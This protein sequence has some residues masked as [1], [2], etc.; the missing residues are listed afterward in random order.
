MLTLPFLFFSSH[1][2]KAEL[3][4]GRLGKGGGDMDVDVDDGEFHL[5]VRFRVEVLLVALADGLCSSSF[6]LLPTQLLD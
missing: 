2:E 4:A 3:E 5:P 6:G 1:R